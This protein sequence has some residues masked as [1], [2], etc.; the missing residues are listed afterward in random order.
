VKKKILLKK[1]IVGK[2]VLWKKKKILAKKAALLAKK[3]AIIR[4]KKKF[5]KKKFWKKKKKFLKKKRVWTKKKIIKAAIA[6]QLFNKK[7]SNKKGKPE[8]IPAKKKN[9]DPPSSSSSN[10]TPN[11]A[12]G[13]SESEDDNTKLGAGEDDSLESGMPLLET[14]SE[15]PGATL[16][17]A[18]ETETSTPSPESSGEVSPV[19]EEKPAKG[20]GKGKK[21]GIKKYTPRPVNL[22]LKA[23]LLNRFNQVTSGVTQLFSAFRSDSYED[24]FEGDDNTLA[25]PIERWEFPYNYYYPVNKEIEWKRFYPV[26]L[27]VVYRHPPTT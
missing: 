8:G 26:T 1:A 5:L 2:A 6:S 12:E 13:G 25:F 24:S 16:F 23:D 4:S 20:K 7:G 17:A 18:S 22:G 27:K 19:D 11:S 21:K 3:K 10:P 15:S 9:R 14:V